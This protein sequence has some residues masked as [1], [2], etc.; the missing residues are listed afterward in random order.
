MKKYR[1][2]SGAAIDTRLRILA[3][4]REAVVRTSVDDAKPLHFCRATR[5]DGRT[6]PKQRRGTH[7]IRRTSKRRTRNRIYRA[8]RLETAVGVRTRETHHH[9]SEI[10]TSSIGLPLGS[11]KNRGYALSP[12]KTKPGYPDNAYQPR[13]RTRIL[14][15]KPSARSIFAFRQVHFTRQKNSQ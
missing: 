11:D 4:C 13:L 14:S 3:F 15:D 12:D 5:H 10:G 7:N 2:A 6:D 9:S 8:G 1:N